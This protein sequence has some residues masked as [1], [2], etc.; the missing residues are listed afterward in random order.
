MLPLQSLGDFDSSITRLKNSAS[1]S[2]RSFGSG[3]LHN[4]VHHQFSDSLSSHSECSSG[5]GVKNTLLRLPTNFSEACLAS[6]AIDKDP[7]PKP[8]KRSEWKSILSK[9]QNILQAWFFGVFGGLM[10]ALFCLA[11]NVFCL[12]WARNNFDVA[13]GI[14]VVFTGSCSRIS[15]ITTYVD[16]AINTISTLLLATSCNA[17]QLLLSATRDEADRAH[18]QG[19]WVHIGA[20][21]SRNIKWIKPWRKLLLLLLLLSSAPLH[22]LQVSPFLQKKIR[23]LTDP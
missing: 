5:L 16:L 23:N 12:I 9:V 14:A 3:D 17:S 10:I 4:F 18:A 11:I 13:D 1:D 8:F 22:L 7:H 6:H 20:A 2:T 21:G 19:D 15:V